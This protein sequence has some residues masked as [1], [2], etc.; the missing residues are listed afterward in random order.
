[1]LMPHMIILGC[2][3]Y[4]W[5]LSAFRNDLVQG[6]AIALKYLLPLL[7]GI[8][9][10]LRPDQSKSVLAAA[11]RAFLAVS[12]IAGAYGIFQHLDPQPWDRFWM[13]ASKIDSIGL[14][15]PGKVRVFSTMNSPVSFAAYATCGLLLFGF[16]NRTFIPRLLVPFAAILPLSLAL[17]LT[18][19]RTAWISAAASL[20]V[21]LLFPKVRK[22]AFVL[23]VCLACGIAVALLFTSFGDTVGSRLSSLGGNVSSDGSGSARIDDYL[24]VFSG[25]SRYLFGVGFGPDDDRQMNALD[26]LLLSSAVQMGIAVGVL[27]TIAVLWA[28]IQAV[29]KTGSHGDVMQTVASALVVG[30]L[31][32]FLLV[33]ISVG[34]VGFLYWMLVG[35]LTGVQPQI[36]WAM[37]RGHRAR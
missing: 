29:L 10:V 34:E 22:R 37:R 33:A 28:G 6:T 12:P 19:V 7:Y 23:M 24:H 15:E 18:G 30:N 17:L 8:C 32:V 21:C 9:L 27:Q 11:A 20:I 36:N 1:M 4:G 13:I 25:D 2:L 14:P 31:V 26:G 16:S 5:A 35:T 3:G